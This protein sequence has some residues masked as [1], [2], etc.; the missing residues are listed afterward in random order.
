[1]KI[2]RGDTNCEGVLGS[3]FCVINTDDYYGEEGKKLHS[4][5]IGKILLDIT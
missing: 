3:M 5:W 1:M 4:F 2:F